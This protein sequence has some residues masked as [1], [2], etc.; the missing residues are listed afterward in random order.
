MAPA[1]TPKMQAKNAR[2][3]KTAAGKNRAIPI[4]EKILP[5][6]EFFYEP[7]NEYLL[8]VNGKPLLNI[9]K[10]R[11]PHKTLEQLIEVIDRI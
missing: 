1:V 9:E 5:P 4:V 6:V 2:R 7:A 10:L 3:I 8:N 11:N